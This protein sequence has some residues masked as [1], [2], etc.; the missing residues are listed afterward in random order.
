MEISFN[1]KGA[2]RKAF[3]KA[4]SEITGAESRYLGTPVFSYQV[5]YFTID[6]EGT[7]IFDDMADTEEIENLLDGLAERGFVGEGKSVQKEEEGNRFTVTVPLFDEES[8]EKLDALIDGKGNLIRKAL[9]AESL[10]YELD[11][12]NDLISFP[13]F[14]LEEPDDGTAYT[15]FISRLMEFVMTAKRI[16]VKMKTYENEKYAF[17][18]F[19]LRLGLIGAEHKHTRK[20]LLRN[21]EGS[22]AFKTVKGADEE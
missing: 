22:S 11:R 9:K 21:L 16:N 3:V 6:R 5:D 10:E 20:V 17:R 19:L 8:L 12:E 14:A 18:C 2:E 7:L 1:V 15:E 4:I 13:W